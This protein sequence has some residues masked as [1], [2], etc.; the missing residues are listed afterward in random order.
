MNWKLLINLN[1]SYLENYSGITDHLLKEVEMVIFFLAG[2]LVK[3]IRE[4]A[5]PLK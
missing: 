1:N 2:K 5:Q 4:I 3:T